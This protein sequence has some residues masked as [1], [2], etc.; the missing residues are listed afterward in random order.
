MNHR[1]ASELLLLCW[2]VGPAAATASAAGFPELLKRIPSEA[3]LLVM[4][5]AERLF[6]SPMAQELGLKGR[7]TEDSARRPLLLPPKAHKLVR[8]ISLDLENDAATFEITLLEVPKG[9]DLKTIA[10]RHKGYVEKVANTDTAWLPEGAY[11]VKLGDEL[12]SVLF[13]ANRQFLSRWLRE[14]SGQASNYLRD[15][16]ADLKQKGP[17]VVIAIDLEDFI[18]PGSL[19]EKVKEMVSLGASPGSLKEIEKT[20]EG[21]RGARFEVTFDKQATAVL[22]VNFDRDVAPLKPIAKPLILKMLSN[23]GL[24]LDEADDWQA[25]AEGRKLTFGGVLKQGGIMRLSSLLELPSGLIEDPEEKVDAANPAVYATQAYYKSVQALVDEL[26]SRKKESFG[27]VG[28][29]AEQYAKKIDRL[30]L[31]NVDKDMQAYGEKVSNLLRQ[32]SFAAK[33]VGIRTGARQSQVWGSSVATYG[34]YGGYYG[35]WAGTEDVKNSIRA[36]ERAAGAATGAEMRRL[37]D[38]ASAAIRKEMVDRYKVEF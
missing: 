11:V 18:S 4:V 34:Y 16:S 31:L 22:I 37:L 3:N 28:K 15:A 14:R 2:M 5:D 26:F 27:Q 32:G 10:G 23:H 7:L 12:F 13:P 25:A 36:Q 29:W 24:M 6:A 35:G 38:E 19:E 33:G 17:Q 30:P 8:A 9:M 1:L 20:L 21:V